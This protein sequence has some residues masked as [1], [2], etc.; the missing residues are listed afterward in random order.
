[1]SSISYTHKTRDIHLD[2]EADLLRRLTDLDTQHARSKSPAKRKEIEAK[3]R[4]VQKFI[5]DLGRLRFKA[6]AA[7]KIWLH[8]LE[9]AVRGSH[10]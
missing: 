2:V 5:T 8:A 4:E 10:E 3:M 9:K 1:M 7:E 6:E